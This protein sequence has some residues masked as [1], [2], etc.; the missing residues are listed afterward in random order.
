MVNKYEKKLEGTGWTMDRLMRYMHRGVGWRCSSYPDKDSLYSVANE[1]MLEG[2]DSWIPGKGAKLE[3]WVNL[4]V[5]SAVQRFM[6]RRDNQNYKTL[7]RLDAPIGEGGKVTFENILEIVFRT[8]SPERKL[9][10]K[11][12]DG[13]IM[14]ACETTAK[15]YRRSKEFYY[16][17]LTVPIRTGGLDGQPDLRGVCRDHKISRALASMHRQ[18]AIRTL[19]KSFERPSMARE[20]EAV[21]YND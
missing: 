5:R 14:K 15:H 12:L 21:M 4:Y 9:Y 16:E 1:A 3:S 7:A 2:I 13:F 11:Q 17:L 6:K 20:L 19:R 8:P 10:L 18:N